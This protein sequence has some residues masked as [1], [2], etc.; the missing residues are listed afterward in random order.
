MLQQNTTKRIGYWLLHLHQLFDESTGQTLAGENLN[1]RQWQVLH[2]ISIGVDSV[3]AVDVAFAPFLAI[4]GADSYRS[5]VDDF[6]RR[7]WI[8]E[9]GDSVRLTD[10]GA[11]AHERAEALVNAHAV[12]SL[13]GISEAEFLAANDV[14]ARIA[15]NLEKA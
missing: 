2:A 6:D 9:A 4:D 11:A 5:I 3:A 12:V 8:A 13:A 7:G 15:E 14:L 1:R 10:A